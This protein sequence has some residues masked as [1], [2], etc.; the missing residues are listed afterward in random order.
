M[1]E[2]RWEAMG[3]G[4]RV[5]AVE[6]ARRGQILYKFCHVVQSLLQDLR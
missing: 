1:L 5:V 3:A 2:A 6:V 4:S